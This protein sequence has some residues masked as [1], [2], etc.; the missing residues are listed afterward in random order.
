MH[1]TS[2][3]VVINLSDPCYYNID[4]IGVILKGYAMYCVSQKSFEIHSGIPKILSPVGSIAHFIQCAV[5]C[6]AVNYK[7][8][9][10]VNG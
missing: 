8:S 5:N 6:R 10:V 1:A 9:S 3:R 4:R 7:M 2:Q